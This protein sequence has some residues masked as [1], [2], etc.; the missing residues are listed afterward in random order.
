MAA[1]SGGLAALLDRKVVTQ[2]PLCDTDNPDL[3]NRA[4]CAACG[5]VFRE[6]ARKR[7]RII[8]TAIVLGVGLTAGGAAVVIFAHQRWIGLALYLLGIAPLAFGIVAVHQVAGS[9]LAALAIRSANDAQRMLRRTEW[10]TT[11]LLLYFLAAF[12]GCIPYYLYVERPRQQVIDYQKRF[13]SH[14]AEYAS[15]IDEDARA[16]RSEKPRLVG[17]VVAVEKTEDGPR[18]GKVHVSLPAA[19]RAETPEEV[20]TVV[21]VVWKNT[22]QGKY[23][24]TKAEAFRVDA[25]VKF[26]DKAEKSLMGLAEFQGGPPPKTQ[27][28]QGHGYGAKP[29][30]KIVNYVEVMEQK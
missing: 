11:G 16:E 21:L 8:Q 18:I 13:A 27:P 17:K 20:G 19:M 7:L 2:C 6:K 23:G 24:N 4:Y 12:A 9:L 10:L 15:L 14:L 5:A 30:D 26:I 25:D 29:I 3:E 22:Y 1:N 28:R